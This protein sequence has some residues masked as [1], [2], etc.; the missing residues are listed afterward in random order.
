MSRSPEEEKAL[1]DEALALFAAHDFAKARRLFEQLARGGGAYAS[2]ARYYLAKMEQM[3][4]PTRG[5]SRGSHK[6]WDEELD[7]DFPASVEESAPPERGMPMSPPMSVPPG[8]APGAEAEAAAAPGDPQSL[9]R[10]PHMDLAPTDPRTLKVS[11]Y[12]NTQAFQDG[13]TG[14][15]LVI[16]A[17][18]DQ[19]RFEVDVWLTVGAPYTVDGVPVK[20]L[21]ILRDE[22]ESKP[23]VFTVLRPEGPEPV[24][25]VLFS[26]LFSYQGRPCGRVSRELQ[27]KSEDSLPKPDLRIDGTAEPPD[28]SVRIVRK[29]AE[30]RAYDCFVQ[31]HLLPAYEK[32]VTESWHLDSLAADLVKEKMARFMAKNTTPKGRIAALRGAGARF[33]EASPKIFQKVFWEL[34]DGNRP[35]ETIAILTEE[36]SIPWEL[37]VPKRLGDVDPRPPLGV[38]YLVSRWTARDHIAPP[39][40][41]PL[42]DAF[43]VA[44]KDSRLASAEAEVQLVEQQFTSQRIEP[45]SLDFLDETLEGQGRTL[46]HFICHGKSGTAG[47]QILVL[48]KMEELEVDQFQELPGIQK[49]F[50]TAKPFVFLNACEVGRQEPALVGAGGFAEAFMAMGASAVIA[51]LWSVKDSVAHTIAET[52]Y[53]RINAEPDV[54]FSRILADLRA[55][56]YTGSDGEDTY[57]AYCFYGDPLARRT[58]P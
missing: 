35:L 3:D 47:S 41:V 33:F 40:H 36:P 13:E 46:L 4:E 38:S 17:P 18:L 30:G 26:A 16:D 8:G 21:V 48:E 42:K 29:D 10:T 31:T 5:P 55:R 51:P 20:R 57:A 37:M 25:P 52:F 1:Y 45:A 27:P 11:V 19:N 58:A 28:L 39:Q 22:D 14:D 44:P 32:G 12:T 53:N 54:P 34:I 7:G 50:R 9:R 49:A 56:S 6:P 2:K 43:V 24:G 15:A 23:V